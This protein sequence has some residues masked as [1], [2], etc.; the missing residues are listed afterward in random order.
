MFRD[1]LKPMTPG[2][3]IIHLDPYSVINVI[4]SF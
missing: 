3:I 4:Y 1:K 2:V